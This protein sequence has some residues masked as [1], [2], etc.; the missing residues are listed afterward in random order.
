MMAASDLAEELGQLR[1]MRLVSLIEGITLLALIFIAVPLKH[2]GGYRIATAVMGPIH[3]MAFLLYVWM[4]IQTVSGGG[5]PKRDVVCMV[6]A[7]FI[8]FGAFFNERALR[9]RQTVLAASA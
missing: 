1:R 3:G 2:L 6:V 4:L 5:L 8:P 7:A 9:K